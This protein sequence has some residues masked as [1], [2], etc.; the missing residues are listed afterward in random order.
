MV[1]GFEVVLEDTFVVVMSGFVVGV[2]LKCVFEVVWLGVES[3]VWDELESGL[4]EFEYT[5]VVLIGDG[6]FGIGRV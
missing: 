5:G 1:G 2:V 6:W 4:F 3:F